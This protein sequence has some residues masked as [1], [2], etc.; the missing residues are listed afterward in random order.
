MKAGRL[1]DVCLE[2]CLNQT[3]LS[4]RALDLDVADGPAWGE[5]RFVVRGGGPR[6]GEGRFLRARL[7]TGDRIG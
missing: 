4:L 7:W 5:G 1:V 3:T 6:G 2:A